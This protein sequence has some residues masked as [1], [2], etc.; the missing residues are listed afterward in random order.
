MDFRLCDKTAS[1]KE[2]DHW[3][4]AS[5]G[6][7][8]IS[9]PKMNVDLLYLIGFLFSTGLNQLSQLSQYVSFLEQKS[10]TKN[11]KSQL[12]EAAKDAE[13]TPSKKP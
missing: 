4:N 12:I 10:T 5:H 6:S 2:E 7:V 8:C 3:T 1:T 13:K 9:D 11:I